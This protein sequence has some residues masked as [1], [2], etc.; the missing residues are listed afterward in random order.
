MVSDAV[1]SGR[2]NPEGRWLLALVLLALAA[3]AFAQAPV[4][5]PA[6]PKCIPKRDNAVVVAHVWPE[7]GWSSVRVYFRKEGLADFYYLEM[8]QAEDATYWASLPKPEGDTKVVE[9]QVAVVDAQ[10]R[11]TRGPLDKVQV[12]SDCDLSLSAAELYA[13][14][15]LIVGE[16]V[17]SQKGGAVVGFLCDGIIS[18]LDLAGLLSGDE[19]CC[20]ALMA[21]AGKGKK[22]LPLLLLGGTGGSGAVKWEEEQETSPPSP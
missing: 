13:A 17:Q 20:Q 6:P 15:N 3:S 8:E 9:I 11:E 12:S 19:Y 5:S 2:A 7:T 21:A 14:Q 22:L 16:T 18:R 1:K 10:S 4:I